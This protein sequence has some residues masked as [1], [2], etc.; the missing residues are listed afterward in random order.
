MRFTIPLLPENISWQHYLPC[1]PEKGK[2]ME[3]L[4]KDYLVEQKGEAGSSF[5]LTCT[6]CGC[7]WRTEDAVSREIAAH[8][9]SINNHVC[10]FCGRAV[11]DNC[12][13]NVKGIQLCV[14]CAAILKS[15]VDT[16]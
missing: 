9:A 11:C 4:L 12:Y 2:R 15:K 6:I 7:T 1:D 10:H 5:R 13:G 16:K 8:K 14:R 3:R